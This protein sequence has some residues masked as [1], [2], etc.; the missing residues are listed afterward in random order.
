[1]EGG[2]SPTGKHLLREPLREGVLSCLITLMFPC[3]INNSSPQK[4]TRLEAKS[5]D[6]QFINDI[7]Q[8]MNCS[9]FEAKAVLDTVHKVYGNFFDCSQELAPGKAKFMVISVEDSPAK[10]LEEATKVCVTLTIND[11]KEDLPIKEKHGVVFLRQHRLSRICNEAF[12]QGG[13]LTVEDIANRIF[14]CGERTIVR[15]LK[16]LRN[17]GI[18]VPLRSTIKD[19]GR[20]LSHRSLIVKEWVKGS[21]YT[22]IAR[23]TNHSIKA[24]NNYVGKFKQVVALMKEGYDVHTIAFLTKIS[25][26]LAEEYIDIKAHSTIVPSRMHEL[27][28]L[29]KKRASNQ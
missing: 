8:G 17:Q 27:E 3:M 12:M 5:L 28:T 14:C 26:R 19:M 13:L 10:K 24:I 18:F 9:S 25:K 7:I 2:R 4:W 1:M 21:E 22:E 29:L 11:D 23:K 16:D 6:S 20:T 15:D